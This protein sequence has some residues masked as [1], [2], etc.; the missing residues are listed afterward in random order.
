MFGKRLREARKGRKYTQQNMADILNVALRTYQSYEEESRRPSF[1][2]LV[3]IG[4]ALNTSID[5]LTGRD[6]FLEALGVSVD[7]FRI[8]P[9]ERPK[10]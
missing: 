4:E 6:S 3:E 5:Y 7:V 8:N 1:E 10:T 2:V 9:Q